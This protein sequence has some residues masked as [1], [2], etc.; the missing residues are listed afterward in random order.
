LLHPQLTIDIDVG[1]VGWILEVGGEKPVEA[2]DGPK[3]KGE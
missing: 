1:V 3:P 2:V